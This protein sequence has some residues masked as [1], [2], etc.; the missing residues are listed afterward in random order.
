MWNGTKYV[1]RNYKLRVPK[2]GR[3][4]PARLVL[5][6]ISSSERY[7]RQRPDVLHKVRRGDT[8]SQIANRYDVSMGELMAL[9]GLRS[10]HRIRV[11]QVLRLPVQDAHASALVAAATSNA[12]SQS[13][14]GTYTVRQ[15]D[16]L[17]RIA[18]RFS[19][20]EDNII[21]VN[22]LK[23]RHRIYVGQ[24]LRVASSD[25][26]EPPTLNG[27]QPSLEKP[28]IE[29]KQLAV[30][31]S[32]TDEQQALDAGAA[33]QENTTE[34][35]DGLATPTPQPPMLSADPSDY[36]VSDNATIEVQA[37]ETLGHYAEWL[38]LRASDLRRLNGMRYGTPVVVGRRLR[39]DFSQVSRQAFEARR[40]A[41]HRE[42]QEGF[43]AEFQIIG[44]CQHV[45][46]RGESVWVL[47]Q[48]TYRVPIWLLR[49]YNPDLN[50][51]AVTPGTSLQIPIVRMREEGLPTDQLNGAVAS[52]VC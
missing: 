44:A 47:A 36:T 7:P 21:R 52:Q 48:R 33:S 18:R 24:S 37:A 29:G 28:S 2:V 5:A 31:A 23:D 49:Q 1:P 27:H 9:N 6:S 4:E 35:V 42:L 14:D 34:A 20:S 16:T 12:P 43:F 38:E 3:Q 26:A 13:K 50:L 45:I 39:L 40:L 32:E 41:Y 8:L 46:R 15:G 22:G 25:A 11:G 10:R 30:V 51:G 19:M 17:S